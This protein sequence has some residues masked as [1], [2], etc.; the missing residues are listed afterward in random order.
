MMIIEAEASCLGSSVAI[1]DETSKVSADLSRARLVCDT[2]S[3]AR[4]GREYKCLLLCTQRPPQI[5]YWA[6]R[7]CSASLTSPAQSDSIE[8]NVG[9]SLVIMCSADPHQATKDEAETRARQTREELPVLSVLLV[10][11]VIDGART[12]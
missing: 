6:P 7:L 2:N 10:L 5:Q 9:W 1:R 12:L 11:V 4:A 3:L 8:E